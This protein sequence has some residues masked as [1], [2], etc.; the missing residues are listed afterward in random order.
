MMVELEKLRKYYHTTI[1][2]ISSAENI[3]IRIK[4]Y[5]SYLYTNLSLDDISL[6]HY[7]IFIYF[8]LQQYR[9]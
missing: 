2:T 5:C 1:A 6:I 7:I 8:L 3:R 4:L 9:N